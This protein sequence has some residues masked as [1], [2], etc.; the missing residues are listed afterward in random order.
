M[1]AA[2]GR[3]G[4]PESGASWLS[5]DAG[6]WTCVNYTE[7]TD[8]DTDLRTLGGSVFRGDGAIFAVV[9]SP[10]GESGESR[11]YFACRD[12]VFL[13]RGLKAAFLGEGAVESLATG[14]GAPFPPTIPLRAVVFNLDRLPVTQF[15][16]IMV[17]FKFFPRLHFLDYR[18]RPLSGARITFPGLPGE[19]AVRPAAPGDVPTIAR[20]LESL[21]DAIRP[22]PTEISQAIAGS[23]EVTG[24]T[25]AIL[26]LVDE[27]D[28]GIGPLGFVWVELYGPE[29]EHLFVK[30]LHVAEA[31]RQRGFGRRLLD[32]GLKWGLDR[33]A[34]RAMA[35]VDEDDRRLRR[36]IE[37]VGFYFSGDEEVH[38]I[39]RG[40]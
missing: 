20:Y 8:V 4:P 18:L 33:R 1:L 11:L 6:R 10:E 38:L 2:T 5:D 16:R 35:W 23:T 36:L 32:E 3:W 24:G 22:G 9:P 26:V 29:L 28:P 7:P 13:E 40:E 30:S 37:S 15:T 39:R 17:R 14:E 21:D 19:H 12:A 34:D 31:Y 27:S 25:S